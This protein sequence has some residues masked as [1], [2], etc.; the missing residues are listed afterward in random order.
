MTE[1]RIIQ[2]ELNTLVTTVIPTLK[3]EKAIEK[4]LDELFALGLH[5]LMIIDGYSSDRTV[6]M[7][8]RYPVGIVL[9]HGKGKA[10][11]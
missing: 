9:H 4:V 11:A 6:E 10:G 5:N 2:S 7:A 1:E 3:E 8:S